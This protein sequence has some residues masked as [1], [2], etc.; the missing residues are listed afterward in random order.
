MLLAIRQL[1][2]TRSNRARRAHRRPTVAL[3]RCAGT[4]SPSPA[5]EA[6]ELQE[7]AVIGPLLLVPMG[8]VARRPCV[9]IASVIWALVVLG[10][11]AAA[12]VVAQSMA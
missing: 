4:L 7:H 9:A 12:S 1:A 2:E 10:R 8:C 6:V 5:A 11:A 3:A